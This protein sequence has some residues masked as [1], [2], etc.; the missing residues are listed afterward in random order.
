MSIFSITECRFENLRNYSDTRIEFSDFTVLVG[1]NNEGK[2]SILK[3]INSLFNELDEDFLSGKRQ[4]SKEEESWPVVSRVSNLPGARPTTM[5]CCA[6]L[7]AVPA[8][9]T[10]QPC[11]TTS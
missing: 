7:W 11:G 4:L 2:S 5:Y 3:M 9:R 1:E 8:S 6:S 10:W